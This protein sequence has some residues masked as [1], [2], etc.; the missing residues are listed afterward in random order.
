MAKIV[1]VVAS[2]HRDGLSSRLVNS[3]LEGARAANAEAA[4]I[5]LS[6]YVVP[7]WSDGNVGKPKEL[8]EAFEGM[9]GLVLCAPVYY[10]DVSGLAKDF[11]DTVKLPDVSGIPGLGISVAGGTGKGLTS[12]L[13]T[14]YY[15]FFCKSIRGID[16]LPVSRFNLE[17]AVG[18]A[19]AS[20][21]K[22]AE[23]A[24]SGRNPFRDLAE[25]I[26]Y[27]Q[28]LPFMGYEYVDEMALLVRQLLAAPHGK[29]AVAEARAR[30]LYE[31]GAR[32][33]GEGRKLE[34]VGPIVEAYEML[35]Y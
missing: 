28:A 6:D 5:H 26:A 24:D 33:I 13:K 25:R 27:H 2:L 14:I 20:G 10:L 29:G 23:L 19:R 31:K 17:A 4:L 21:R 3:A 18:Q 7:Q 11:M 15:W 12:A 16:P 35:Y 9:D 1:G 32:L 22:L 34:A 30:D 8:S